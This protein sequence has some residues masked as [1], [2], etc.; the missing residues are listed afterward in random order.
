MVLTPHSQQCGTRTNEIEIMAYRARKRQPKAK[1]RPVNCPFYGQKCAF[2]PFIM[3]C[4][5]LSL[6]KDKPMYIVIWNLSNKTR[7]GWATFKDVNMYIYAFF[8]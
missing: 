2:S 4:L 7:T 1:W 3:L 6:K 5:S 8:T